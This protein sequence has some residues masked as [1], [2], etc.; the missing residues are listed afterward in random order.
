MSIPNFWLAIVLILFLSVKLKLLPA[1]GYQG[2]S[3]VLLPALVLSVEIAPFIIRTLTTSLGEVM[4]STF[5][6]EGR[7]L[8]SR[9]G[10]SQSE[11]SRLR[12]RN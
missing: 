7:V 9:R 11:V 3:Y 1:L 12:M 4:Q 10:S 8:R 5:I 6:D 2:F